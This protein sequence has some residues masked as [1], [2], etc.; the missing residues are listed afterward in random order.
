MV[1]KEGISLAVTTNLR[2]I[3]LEHK[4]N[5]EELAQAVGAHPKS[6]GRIE[7]GE[8]TASLEL[9]LRLSHYFNRTVEDLFK[10]DEI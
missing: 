3:R 1:K 2:Q 8:R 10:I 4:M 5:Q 9:A 6:I 7:R